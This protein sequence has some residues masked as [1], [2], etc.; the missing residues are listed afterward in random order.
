MAV[1]LP[2]AAG[3]RGPD[4]FHENGKKYENQRCTA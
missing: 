1:R 2:E 4:A 3:L